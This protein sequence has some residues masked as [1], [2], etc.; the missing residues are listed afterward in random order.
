MLKKLL[1]AFVVIVAAAAAVVYFLF[2][3][4]AT[5]FSGKSRYFYIPSNNATKAYVLKEL[6]DSSITERTGVFNL[7]AE[8]SGLWTEIKPGRYE[9]RQ[10]IN[11]VQMVRLLKNGTQSPVRL[12]INKFR[13]KEDMAKRLGL[14]LEPDSLQFIQFMDSPD[15]L[16]KLGLDTNTAMTLVIPNTYSVFWNTSANKL[17]H[18]LFSESQ[19]F[20]NSDRLAKAAKLGLTKEQ[21]FILASIVEEE[22]NK[23]D[24]KPVIASVYLNRLKKNM[25]LSADPTVKFALKDFGI[26]RIRFKHISASAASPY[27]TYRNAGLPPG[28]ICTPSIKTIDAVLDAAETNYLFFCARP[29]FS[30]YH[31]FASN[32]KDHF[33]NAIAYQKALDSLLLK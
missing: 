20:W 1:L 6:K 12:V 7:V 31:A 2:F 16:G 18:K 8:R 29:D 27:N 13:T 14:L 22:S 11:I 10:G 24:E 33:K 3:T 5:S 32:E 23:N 28:P 26:K 19:S 25:R 30:G 17:Y 21:A 9:I 4:S 15:S